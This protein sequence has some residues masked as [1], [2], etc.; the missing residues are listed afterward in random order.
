[1]TVLSCQSIRKRRIFDPF[2]ERTVH[3]PTGM[4]YGCGAASYDIRLAEDIQLSENV[5]VLAS[6]IERFTMPH[7]IC[8]VVHDKS[9]LA[10]IGLL[11]QNTFIDPGWHG[12]LTL[13]LTY[14]RLQSEQQMSQQLVETIFGSILIEP[15]VLKAGTPIAQIALH[16]LDEPT[17]RPY[18][19][20][21]QNQSAGKQVSKTHLP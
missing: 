20:H 8:G 18:D 6:A 17:E 1:M 4:T 12:Y 5:I 16:L 2:S 11:V 15:L 9:S 21:Y 7:D 14:H 3:E 10:R 13:E 19:G